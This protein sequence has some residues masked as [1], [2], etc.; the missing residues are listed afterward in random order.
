MST[1]IDQAGVELDDKDD[2]PKTWHVEGGTN[3]AS[4]AT[5][6]I[7]P[8]PKESACLAIST[9]N[10]GKPVEVDWYAKILLPLSV[11]LKVSTITGLLSHVAVAKVGVVPLWRERPA[12][13]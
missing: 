6:S 12:E 4:A 13:V 7:L 5:V 2:Q 3:C 8:M 9:W 11:T 10:V 1:L